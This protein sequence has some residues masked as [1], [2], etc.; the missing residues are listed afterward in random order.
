VMPHGRSIICTPRECTAS[1][2]GARYP[3]RGQ[4]AVTRSEAAV[5]AGRP[6]TCPSPTST[7]R[8]VP[9]A[10]SA[11]RQVYSGR[12]HDREGF[13]PGENNSSYKYTKY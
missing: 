5:A 10:R 1:R 9:G 8:Q 7:T 13:F 4:I 6:L 11:Q 3:Q 12:R 2:V